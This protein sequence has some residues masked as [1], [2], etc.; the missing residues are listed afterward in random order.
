MGFVESSVERFLIGQVLKKVTGKNN[1]KILVGQ[2]PTSRAVLFEEGYRLV[3]VLFGGRIQV[4][5]PFAAGTNTINELPVTTNK[6]KNITIFG[7]QAL[8]NLRASSPPYYLAI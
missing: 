8:P 4:H 3:Q 5:R 6:I 1:I 7:N 2:V